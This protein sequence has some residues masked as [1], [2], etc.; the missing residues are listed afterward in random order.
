M[1]F[2]GFEDICKMLKEKEYLWSRSDP[3][4]FWLNKIIFEKHD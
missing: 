2:I 1:H 3:N 4:M